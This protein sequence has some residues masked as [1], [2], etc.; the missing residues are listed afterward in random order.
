MNSRLLLAVVIGFT[1]LLDSRL[2]ASESVVRVTDISPGRGSSYPS[3]ITVFGN[4]LVFRANDGLNNVELW[5]YDGTSASLISDI[6]PGVEGSSPSELTAFAGAVY[7]NADSNGGPRRLW[8]YDGTN[9]APVPNLNPPY[10]FSSSAAW[11]P[12]VFAGS[13]WWA[14]GGRVNGFNGTQFWYLNTPPWAQMEV[15]LWNGAL[16]YGAG[17][18]DIELWRYN[19]VSQSQVA[20]INQFESSYPDR[21]CV[22]R[23]KLF[24]SAHDNTNGFE[25][26]S[27]DGASTK[28]EADIFPGGPPPYANSSQPAGLTVFNN[29]LYFS[30][31]D[32]VHGTELWRF[33]GTNAS[34]VADI[35]TNAI[36]ELGG[37]HLSDSW[38]TK[39]TVWRNNLY[40]IATQDTWSRAGIW[41]FDGTNASLVGGLS[42]D[43]VTE[44]IVFKDRLYFDCDD[45]RSGRELWRIEPD[46]AP[47]MT[48][49]LPGTGTEIELSPA[50]TGRYVVE[51][52]SD[53]VS[54]TAIA[55]NRT[56]NGAALFIDLD[57]TNHQSR[58]YRTWKLP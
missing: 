52:S 19:G 14:G 53:L 56:T 17:S 27:Y 16:Y 12:V 23:N 3:W 48:L 51:A 32:G 47:R 46:V 18:T 7:F 31:D 1:S 29:A 22:F 45:G 40:F 57:R 10:Y 43:G 38:P 42:D 13:L 5:R 58:M 9:T 20:N 49:S 2:V 39:L 30:A 36:Y 37:D 26:W 4:E 24:F 44:L 35:N 34:L 15:V 41:K 21:F 25:L 50:E 33:D 11:K 6:R 55:T 8:R 28:L 54:W